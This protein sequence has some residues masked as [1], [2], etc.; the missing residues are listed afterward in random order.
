[1]SRLIAFGCS[2][3][4]GHGLEDCHVPPN[5]AGREPS[6]Y[7]WPSLLGKM[8]DLDVVNCSNP[9][10][11]NAHILWKLLNFDF[12]E[13]DICV[14]MWSHFGRYPF[15]NLKYDHNIVEWTG[16]WNILEKYVTSLDQEN[17]NVRNYILL[18]HA[19]LY[20]QSKNIKHAFMIGTSD[21]LS[22]EE[23]NITIPSLISKKHITTLLADIALD[24]AHPGPKTH[25]N[26]AE[27]YYN[28][29]NVLY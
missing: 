28:K 14:V 8:M 22:Y 4:Y 12:T 1:M 18:H 5:S 11:S 27:E 29:L 6:K 26:I 2:Y 9:G 19:Y 7:A 25:A 10:A 24:N 13:Q 23:T 17:L 3:T 20:L 21:V 15:G 16:Y